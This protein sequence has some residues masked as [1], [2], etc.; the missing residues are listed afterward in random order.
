MKLL[1]ILYINGNI[2]FTISVNI[3]LWTKNNNSRTGTVAS[4]INMLNN[5][6]LVPFLSNG[7]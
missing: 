2:L 7:M 3:D 5:E 6:N 1:I 4:Y